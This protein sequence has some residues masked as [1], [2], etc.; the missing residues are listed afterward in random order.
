MLLAALPCPATGSV[1]RDALKAPEAPGTGI[2]LKGDRTVFDLSHGQAGSPAQSGP[3]D[4]SLFYQTV[5]SKGGNVEFNFNPVSPHG[6]TGVSTYIIPGAERRFTADEVSAI[7]DFVGNGGNLIV[8][9]RSS[10]PVA[11]LTNAF[12]IAVSNFKINEKSGNIG[13]EAQNFS[14]SNFW[15]HPVTRGLEQITVYGAWAVLA[16]NGALA[17]ATTSGYAWVDLDEDCAQ[18]PS[19]P[20]QTFG[21]IAIREAGRGKVVVVSD[22]SPF[23]N[24]NLIEADNRRLAENILNWFK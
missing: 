10:G 16:E 2:S 14:V 3:L 4:Y 23:L 24:R 9:V 15:P 8:L 19:D 11:E 1:G 6:L 17:V 20:V 5:L 13:N 7:V 12:G 18:G 22:N 21:V